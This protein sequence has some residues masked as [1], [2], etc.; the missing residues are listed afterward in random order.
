MSP[1]GL[2]LGRFL[3][4]HQSVVGFF[5]AAVIFAHI[6]H[7]LVMVIVSGDEKDCVIWSV[8]AFFKE[9]T[10]FILVGHIQ[11]ILEITESCMFVGMLFKGFVSQGFEKP[12]SWIGYTCIVFAFDDRGF[13][14][15]H[16]FVVVEVDE[17]VC[18]RL[19]DIF[20]VF[21]SCKDHKITGVVICGV[22]VRACA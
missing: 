2:C 3:R 4:S 1:F 10:V 14:F 13:G 7:Q 19:D 22:A 21:S 15:E 6:L 18:F 20:Q 12:S 17:P 11:D 5:P 8:E 9:L 16:L